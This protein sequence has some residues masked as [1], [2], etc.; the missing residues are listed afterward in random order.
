MS[1]HASDEMLLPSGRLG[2][3]ETRQ[4]HGDGVP[5][6]IFRAAQPQRYAKGGHGQLLPGAQAAWQR[7]GNAQQL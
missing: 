4:R 6:L 7:V 3:A 2:L 5:A 1:K